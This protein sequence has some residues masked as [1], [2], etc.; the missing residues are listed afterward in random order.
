M[1]NT[2]N[3]AVPSPKPAANKPIPSNKPGMGLRMSKFVRETWIELKK[4]SWPNRSELEKGTLL[5][6]A[7]VVIITGFIGGFDAI[8]GFLFKQVGL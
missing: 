4:T 3:K 5:V 6:L 2:S 8:L 7:A 1:A